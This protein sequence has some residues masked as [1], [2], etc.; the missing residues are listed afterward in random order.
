MKFYALSNTTVDDVV[1]QNEYK[2]ARQIGAI[3][4]GETCL[5]FKAKLKNYYIPYADIKKC[6]RRVMGV[7]LK[8]CCG[9]GE[10][11]V[12]NLVV[13]DEER[14]LAVIQLPGTRAAQELMKDLKE[15]MPDCDFT[16]P[17]R[18]KPAVAVQG[19]AA[20]VQ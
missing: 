20:L 3:R 1:L 10:M 12:E 15:R 7:N 5:Q 14:E 19:G 8:M 4:L 6:F 17:K 16:A 2:A 18:D 13:C 11:Q 9:K